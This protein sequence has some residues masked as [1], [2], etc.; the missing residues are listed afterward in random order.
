MWREWLLTILVALYSIIPESLV[1]KNKKKAMSLTL[2]RQ[3]IPQLQQANYVHQILPS[4]N[5]KL[6]L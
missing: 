2:N 3:V 4:L 1:P 6:N 5:V